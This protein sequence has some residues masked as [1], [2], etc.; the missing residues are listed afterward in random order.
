MPYVQDRREL[1]RIAALPQRKLVHGVGFPVGGTRL[2]DAR[3]LEPLVETIECL[4]SPW[5]SEHLGFN[6][7]GD[8]VNTGVLLPPSQTRAGVDAAGAALGRVAGARPGAV[9]GGT[10]VN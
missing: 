7:F 5:A 10:R 1:E 2:P 4:G 3:H 9:R 6:S 8:G